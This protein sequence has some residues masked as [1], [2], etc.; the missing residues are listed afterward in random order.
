MRDLLPD[1]DRLERLG[2]S[3]GRAVVTSVWG[4][5]PRPEGS[6]MLATAD[7]DMAGS[8][9]G[10]CVEGATVTEIGEAIG[11]GTPRLV[12]FGVSDERAWEV[13][14]ACGGTIK[15]FV[16]PT[17]RPE[18]LAAARGPGGEVVATVVDGPGVGSLIRVFED[19]RIEGRLGADVPVA[20]VREAALAALRRESSHTTMV[21]STAGSASVFLEVF[22]R[23]PRLVIFGGVHIAVA[24]VPLARALGYRTIV[25]D[26][27]PAFL[28]RE[29]FPDA[30]ELI[31]G[32][33]EAAFGQIGIDA[34]CYVCILSHDPKFDEPALELAL[35]SPARYIGAIGSRKTQ[36]ARRERLKA[37]GFTDDQVARVHG[38]IGLDLGGR[39]P[40]E[41]ALAILAEMTAVRYGGGAA[42]TGG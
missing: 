39:H 3:V 4:S 27:R 21:E 23:Q 41:T 19:G 32:W 36:A 40:A 7:G 12:T 22:A 6:S 34:A 38:P 37:A 14:L 15:V 24:L 30:D 17:V 35:R 29:R 8:V 31:L 20:P 26:G 33:P 11:R 10:G 5:A 28:G 1:Y 9:S 18:I 13:G 42:R 25:A 16:E 2:R